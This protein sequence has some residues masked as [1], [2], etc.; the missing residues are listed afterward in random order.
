MSD[1][2]LTITLTD[3]GLAA[4]AAAHGQGLAAK[5]THVAV[6]DAGYA[7]DA[8]ATTL[9]NE[10]VRV[11]LT[12]GGAVAPRQVLL[13]GT[14]PPGETEFFIREMGY[15][16]EDG[17][18]LGVWS[19]PEAPLGWAGGVTPWFFKLS[20]AWS[21]LPAD[22]ITVIIADDAATAGMALDLAQL[23]GKVRHTV[24]QGGGLT[25]D[26]EDDT[27]LTDAI[28]AMIAAGLATISS[29]RLHGQCR[30][31]LSGANL[32]LGAHNGNHLVIGG[33][34]RTIPDGGISLAPTG[35]V[36]ATNYYIYAVF[37]DGELTLEADVTSH[38]TDSAT[39]IETKAGDTSRTLVGM[40]RTLNDVTW[41]DEVGRRFVL[42]WFNRSEKMLKINGSA[43]TSSATVAQLSGLAEFLTWD[44]SSLLAV[45]SANASGSAV[46]SGT[47]AQ[48]MFDGA[49]SSSAGT[50]NVYTNG[51]WMC[52]ASGEAFGCTEGYH[53]L[54]MAGNT[55]AGTANFNYSLSALVEG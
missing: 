33:A 17:T 36:A 16:L 12:A 5:I 41:C 42:S 24:E 9:V 4:V 29:P 22:A 51:Y 31:E 40:A 32:L 6:G 37:A 48:I 39:G 8:S 53:N 18:L 50:H 10:L 44:S 52:L 25:W 2:T 14:I 54:A 30:L 11:E 38:E 47:Q 27:Q 43:S 45:L 28:A 20:F 34:V 13:Q 26:G 55:G 3:A 35:L 19:D 7:P 1:M 23:D 49:T 21:S 15:F 46:G